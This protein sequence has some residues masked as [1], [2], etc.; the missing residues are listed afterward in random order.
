MVK[1][2][3]KQ[4]LSEKTRIVKL[5]LKEY[6]NLASQRM[7]TNGQNLFLKDLATCWSYNSS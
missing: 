3:A 5:F 2:K 6:L 7:V 4:A 1:H